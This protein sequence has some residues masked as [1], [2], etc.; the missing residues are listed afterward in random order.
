MRLRRLP[1][2]LADCARAGSPGSL[3][4]DAGARDPM[5]HALVRAQAAALVAGPGRALVSGW[6]HGFRQGALNSGIAVPRSRLTD[7]NRRPSLYKSA[8]LPLS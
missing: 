8:A 4:L 1:H 7:L 3:S 6:A 5:V 2:A